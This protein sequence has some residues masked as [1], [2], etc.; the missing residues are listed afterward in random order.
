MQVVY[1][2]ALV[3]AV[4]W[5]LSPILSKRG[6]AGGGSSLQASLT[7][8]VV[9]TTLYAIALLALQGPDALASVTPASAGLFLVAGLVG[10]AL[11]LPLGLMLA[12][13][14][15]GLVTQTI[16]DLYFVLSVRSVTVPPLGVAKA[17]CLGV[18]AAVA[19]ALGVHA[20]V[21]VTAVGLGLASWWT[22][23]GRARPAL[24]RRAGA[25]GEKPPLR[26]K[27]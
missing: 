2:L 18:G 3:P 20:V 14:L 16:N 23:P 13:G 1:A 27:S 19:A 4:L 22:S 24:P 10:T 21:A 15:L 9:D 11:G 26:P 25:S 12:E 17:V 6:M 8:V 7:V 5:G